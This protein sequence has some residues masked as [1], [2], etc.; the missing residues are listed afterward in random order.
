MKIFSINSGLKVS[1]L[2]HNNFFFGGFLL[3]FIQS[4]IQ[5]EKNVEKC[6]VIKKTS[7]F[8]SLFLLNSFVFNIF[9]SF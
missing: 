8:I 2:F 6:K 5:C 4:L 9:Y 3:H 7:E 1:G